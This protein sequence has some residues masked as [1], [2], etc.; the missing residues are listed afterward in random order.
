[1]SQIAWLGTS[2]YLCLFESRAVWCAALSDLSAHDAT[3][4][5]TIQ[6]DRGKDVLNANGILYLRIMRLE[7]ARSWGHEKGLAIT[8]SGY[9]N[10]VMR[11]AQEMKPLS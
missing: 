4:N 1:M 5:S 2:W 10:P 11:R 9:R 6:D 8:L 7:S 3:Q